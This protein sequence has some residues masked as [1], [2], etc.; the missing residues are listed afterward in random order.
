MLRSWQGLHVGTRGAARRCAKH[1]HQCTPALLATLQRWALRGSNVDI[2][3]PCSVCCAHGMLSRLNSRQ[4]APRPTCCAPQAT[5]RFCTKFWQQ[6]CFLVTIHRANYTT[7]ISAAQCRAGVRSYQGR[8][9][10]SA[11]TTTSK[12]PILGSAEI[13]REAR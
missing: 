12:Q 8:G 13:D 7:A 9:I 11:Q 5:R 6:H 10:A 3:R 1:A 4:Q 2:S